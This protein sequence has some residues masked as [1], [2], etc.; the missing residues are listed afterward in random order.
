MN[1]GEVVQDSTLNSFEQSGSTLIN[2]VKLQARFLSLPYKVCKT[3]SA[4]HT[5]SSFYPQSM[6]LVI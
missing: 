6:N 4:S 5:V 1:E 3:F 2:N